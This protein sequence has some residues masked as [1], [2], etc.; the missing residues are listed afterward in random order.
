M[1]GNA[2]AGIKNLEQKIITKLF[3]SRGSGGRFLEE[4]NKKKM[5]VSSFRDHHA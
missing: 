2:R 3:R 1:R 5:M 4:E